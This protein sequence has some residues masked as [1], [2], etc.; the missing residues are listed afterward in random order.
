MGYTQTSDTPTTTSNS[1]ISYKNACR[2]IIPSRG[3]S[4]PS[5]ITEGETP[6]KLVSTTSASN[7]IKH[8]TDPS[9]SVHVHDY[10]GKIYNPVTGRADPTDSL[11][12]G[13]DKEIWLKALTNEWGHCTQG[14]SKSFSEID[15]VLGNLSSTNVANFQACR[16]HLLLFIPNCSDTLNDD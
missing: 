7:S 12:K 2:T 13:P 16:S 14:L 5:A 6:Q 11:I 8:P 3:Q 1:Y 9:V 15:A 4:Q 10:N